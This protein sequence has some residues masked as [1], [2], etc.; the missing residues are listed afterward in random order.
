MK[1][2]SGFSFAIASQPFQ[3]FSL[4]VDFLVLDREFDYLWL[5]AIVKKR[6]QQLLEI[7]HWRT[8]QKASTSNMSQFILFSQPENKAHQSYIYHYINATFHEL[9]W[10]KVFNMYSFFRYVSSSKFKMLNKL[11]KRKVWKEI[12]LMV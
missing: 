6:Q 12:A 5:F 3:Y 7:G 2:E 8:E 1:S 9:N 4:E 11:R 10:N